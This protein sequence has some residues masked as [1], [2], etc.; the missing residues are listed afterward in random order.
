MKITDRIKTF[1]DACEYLGLEKFDLNLFPNLPSYMT[2]Y[3][4]FHNACCMLTII[5]RAL[6]ENW[7]P[8]WNNSKERKYYA[9]FYMDS[10]NG[11]RLRGVHNYGDASSVAFRLVFK[12]EELAQYSAIQFKDI[13]KVYM[14]YKDKI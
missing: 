3:A 7:K 12:S 6:N 14:G 13:W 11:F 4:E 1:E 2:E 5:T 8:D 10:K 9:W